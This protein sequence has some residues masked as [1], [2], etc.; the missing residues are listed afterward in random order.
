MSQEADDRESLQCTQL[1][2][3]VSLCDRFEHA[4]R[5]G[6][7]PRIESFLT[8]IDDREALLE[9]LLLI[10]L[11]L[12]KEA[13]ELVTPDDYRARFMNSPTVVNAVFDRN[14][15]GQSARRPGTGRG[16]AAGPNEPFRQATVLASSLCVE[17]PRTVSSTCDSPPADD[18]PAT[19][20][21]QEDGTGDKISAWSTLDAGPGLDAHP[22]GVQTEDLVRYSLVKKHAQGGVGEV[23]LARDNDLDRDVA[24]KRLQPVKAGDPALRARFLREAWI[25]GQLQH[26]GIVPVFELARSTGEGQDYYTM[27]FIKGRT[28]TESAKEYHSRREQG[29]AR[30]LEL[31]ELL[32]AFVS[33]CQVMAY[34]HSRGI[35]HR[36]LKGQNIAL[37]DYGEVMVLDWGMAKVAGER[38][39]DTE[40]PFQN[41]ST[42][43]GPLGASDRFEGIWDVT[44][45]GSIL[46]T[47]SYMPPEQA[48]GQLELV[49]ARS[50][51]YGLGAILYEILTGEPP[52]RGPRKE[53]LRQVVHEAP[54]PPRQR[55]SE[56]TPALEA[57]CLKCLAKVPS[58]RYT[59][60]AELAREVQ[61]YLSDEPVKAYA[62]PW[63]G[64]LRRWMD[65]HRTSTA[66]AVATLVVA[67]ICLA[68]ATMLL[69]LA[70]DR[71]AATLS[72]G[73]EPRARPE[74][75]EPVFQ[76][77]Q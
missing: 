57:V 22:S 54:K 19:Q 41:D 16:L 23:W 40:Q 47:P 59:S 70:N 25:T 77:G 58:Q 28:L 34:A 21:G 67:T 64:R 55:V 13:G 8:A 15:A 30:P 36:D 31:R 48:L 32:G 2:R 27:R 14:L 60:A 75:R 71:E 42:G 20:V 74:R 63:T 66:A 72:R 53:V 18:G 38:E 26:P 39:P 73:D 76:Q 49:D 5:Q 68:I 61:R 24:L 9:R 3:I 11:D 45:D 6:D 44:G 69:K 65:R 4:W 52:F 37:G 33:I 51:V 46:G 10:E 17:P 62:E 35:I 56:V 29:I 43:A 1:E 50:D 12:R 7:R